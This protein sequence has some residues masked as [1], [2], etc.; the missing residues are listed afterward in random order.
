M[1]QERK[2]LLAE[3]DDDVAAALTV[4]AHA[5]MGK[6]ADAEV[7]GALDGVQELDVRW[8]CPER[9][10]GRASSRWGT[11]NGDVKVREKSFD[12][13]KHTGIPKPL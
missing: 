11:R 6:A 7:S 1:Y 12:G 13:H 5:R 3:L 2:P 10:D 8:T 9:N 4:E